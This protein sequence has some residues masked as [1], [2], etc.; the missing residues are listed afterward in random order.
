MNLNQLREK[1]TNF[2]C[3]YQS[4]LYYQYRSINLFSSGFSNNTL[5]YE[6][7]NNRNNLIQ[8]DIDGTIFFAADRQKPKKIVE[9]YIPDYY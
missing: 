7:I 4:H 1:Q 2:N 9:N 3:L 8:S 6:E 5:A